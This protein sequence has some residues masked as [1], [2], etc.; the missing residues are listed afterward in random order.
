MKKIIGFLKECRQELKKVNWPTRDDVIV[1]TK[2]VVVSVAII[3]MLLGLLDYGLFYL[4]N[5]IL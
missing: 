5:L 1:S 4:V 3:S 2:T